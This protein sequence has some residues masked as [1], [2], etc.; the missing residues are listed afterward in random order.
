MATITE[1]STNPQPPPP[2]PAAAPPALPQQQSQQQSSTPP[3]YPEMIMAAIEALNEKEG[4]NK[5]S[6]SKQIES[7]HPDLPPAH[8]TLLSHHLNKMKQSGQLVLV[9]NN[10]MKPDPNA[11]PKRGRGRPPKPKLP[12]PP[13]TVSGPPRPRGRPPKPRDPFAPVASPKKKTTSTGTGRPRG[14]P[15][16]NAS[17][18][19][20]AASSGGAPPSGARR[21]RGRPP[22]AKPAVAPVAG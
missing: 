2:A 5:T 20:P 19:V 16:K 3:Q 6:I 11:P 18:A 14:R 21:G 8:S 7:T 17:T 15:P 10:Y 13:G 4:S 22:K 1:D 12:T 9:K